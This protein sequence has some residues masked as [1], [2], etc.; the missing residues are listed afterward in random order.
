[1]T[2]PKRPVVTRD[3]PRP[4]VPSEGMR[5]GGVSCTEECGD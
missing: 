5:A 4:S 3:A 1:M 2:R